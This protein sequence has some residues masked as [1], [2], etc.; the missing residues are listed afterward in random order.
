MGYVN[1]EQGKDFVASTTKGLW[2]YSIIAIPLVVVTMGLY[3]CFELVNN[4]RS[5]SRKRDATS[6]I[7][8]AFA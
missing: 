1:T 8:N 6:Q 3:L 7:M 5:E 4:R 2:V